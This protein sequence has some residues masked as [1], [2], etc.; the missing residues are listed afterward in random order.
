[1]SLG[2][3]LAPAGGSQLS[4]T[5]LY[6]KN[7]PP[8]ERYGCDKCEFA[9]PTGSGRYTYAVDDSGQRIVCPHPGEMRTLR[10]VTGLSYGEAR[11]A[12]RLGYADFCVCL[13][14]LAQCDLDLDRDPRQCAKCGSTDV[15]T[16]NE[17]I[18]RE[19][20]QCHS[21]TIERSSPIRWKLDDNWESMP[22]PSIV[23]DLVEFHNTRDV[24]TSLSAAAETANRFEK[25]DFFVL[26]SRL[27]DWWEGDYGADDTEPKDTK[28]MDPEWTW[29]KVLP[30]VLEISP[31]LARIVQIRGKACCFTDQVTSEERCG[32]KNYVRKHR[33]HMLYT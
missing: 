4:G 6:G 10:K 1:M 28:K 20:P 25:Y 23:K 22:V 26:A 16:A 31:E 19:C 24:P 14:C 3:P 33:E 13:N 30:S 32:M 27:L 15:R 11:A 17:M 18:G 8:I 21:G 9:L 7:M 12:G 29:C 5:T 2:R